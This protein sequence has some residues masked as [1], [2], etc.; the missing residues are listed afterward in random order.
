MTRTLAP[1]FSEAA[2]M[3]DRVNQ[4]E[5][6]RQRQTVTF[7]RFSLDDQLIDVYENCSQPDW[8]GPGSLPV[9]PDTLEAAQRLVLSLPQEFRTPTIFG[10][11]DGHV[12]MEWY[13]HPRR[14][15]TISLS[16]QRV[17]HWA[18]LIGDEDPRG[19]CHFFNEVPQ[20]LTY[21]ISRICRT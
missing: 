5:I 18:A 17:I 1:G 2:E 14:L 6:R 7:S 9:Q 4:Q 13:V 16:P 12:G 11:P 3:L 21:W 19:S 15:L 20:T 8:E 10:E